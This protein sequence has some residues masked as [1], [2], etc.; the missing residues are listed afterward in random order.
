MQKRQMRRVEERSFETLNRA[1]VWCRMTSD[2]AVEGVTNYWVTDRTQVN[3]NLVCSPG[4]DG[5]PGQRHAVQVL[6]GRDT[7][8]G[9]S[10]SSRSDRDL[11]SLDRVS[12]EREVDASTRLHDPPDESQIPFLD[13]AI[14]ELPGKLGVR[15]VV[16]CHH[17]QSGCSAIQ[18]VHDTRPSLAADATQVFDMMQQ[19]VDE[20]AL[21]VPRGRMDHHAGR[22]VDDNDVR[23]VIDDRQWEGLRLR[24]RR[25]GRRNLQRDQLAFSDD[26]TGAADFATHVGEPLP[27]QTLNLRACMVRDLSGED[28]IEP[29]AAVLGRDQKMNEVAGVVRMVRH[30]CVVIRPSASF[31]ATLTLTRTASV[32]NS[33]H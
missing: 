29:L 31:I 28:M 17:H 1:V 14:V 5:D 20:R 27:D 23:I 11:L 2:A 24:R 26:R 18:T 30:G 8:H 15:A 4:R 32:L 22:F 7:G 33:P 13:L 25:F 10:G 6:G 12:T 19:G 9:L 3:T 16:L 21:A